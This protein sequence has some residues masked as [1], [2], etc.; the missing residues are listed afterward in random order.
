VPQT[1]W[2]IGQRVTGV[3]LS[4]N[5]RAGAKPRMLICSGTVT[6]SVPGQVRLDAEPDLATWSGIYQVFFSGDASRELVD[7][8]TLFDIQAVLA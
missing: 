3:G 8:C 1:H 2:R 4:L 6:E 5:E 7:F